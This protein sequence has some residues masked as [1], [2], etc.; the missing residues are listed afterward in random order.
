MNKPL[1]AFVIVYKE[2]V[3]SPLLTTTREYGRWLEEL[4]DSSIC[5]LELYTKSKKRTGESVLESHPGTKIGDWFSKQD[6]QQK[7]LQSWFIYQDSTM[8]DK[9]RKY[10]LAEYRDAIP[11]SVNDEQGRR[12]LRCYSLQQIELYIKSNIDKKFIIEG[13]YSS[14]KQVKV[15]ESD[16]DKMIMPKVVLTRKKLF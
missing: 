6:F 14:P 2:E 11:I 3:I 8:M 15:R 1:N 16:F 5:Q 13:L 7:N 4:F 10:K 12:M 9:L